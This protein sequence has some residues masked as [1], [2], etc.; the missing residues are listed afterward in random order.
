M[1]LPCV[2]AM[3]YS[4]CSWFHHL[5]DVPMPTSEVLHETGS[6]EWYHHMH[7]NIKAEQN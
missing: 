1:Q 4:I 5:L 7:T 2:H 3:V 6:S